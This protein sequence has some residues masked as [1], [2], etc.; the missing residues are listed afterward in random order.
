MEKLETRG[1]CALWGRREISWLGYPQGDECNCPLIMNGSLLSGKPRN[2]PE[3]VNRVRARSVS[4][5][6]R[7]LTTA[8]SW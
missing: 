5:Y 1:Y 8:K 4:R 7:A 6:S 3:S 2:H